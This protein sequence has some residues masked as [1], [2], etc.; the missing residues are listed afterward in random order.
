MKKTISLLLVLSIMLSLVACG[1]NQ[2]PKTEAKANEETK[3]EAM[4]IG[5]VCIG[6]ENEGYS[7]AHIDALRKAVNELGLDEKESLIMKYN[8]AE[9]ASA[10]DACVDLAEQGC[11][12]IITNSYSHQKYTQ[13][14]AGEYPDVEFCAMTGDTAKVSG[15]ANFHNAFT[16]IYQGRYIGGAVAGL[17]L[18]E[19]IDEGKITDANKDVDGKIK[20]GYVGAYPFAEVVSGYTAFFLGIRSIVPDV[21]M[22]V[23]YTNSWGNMIAEKEAATALIN[24][25]CVII[26]QHA[27]TTGA[28]SATEE[29]L[30][31]G[32]VCYTVGYN[33]DMVA[34][35]PNA[36]L[37]SPANNWLN[38]YKY[39]V[40]AVMNGEKFD[41]NWAEGFESDSVILSTPTK[42]CANGTQEKINELIQ[43]FKSKSLHVFDV[44]TFTVGG[45]KVESAF[46]T[47]TNG[48]FTPD[49]DEAV[50]DGYFHESYF[51]SAPAFSLRI[52]GIKE[53]N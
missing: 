49:T 51:Q 39:V 22:Q 30:N 26:G 9:D 6:D 32:H 4:K 41:Q 40:K 13:Q 24:D 31:A 16:K 18:K 44:N 17:K 27:D 23:Q 52:D 34:A 42:N 53:L 33:V 46:A 48:D 11:K 8:I 3:T 43:K 36:A 10:Y 35:A 1:N 2:A 37:I 21:A 47:D 45:N 12:L 29:L 5:L 19:L 28:P 50:F 7:F 38:Y 20:I 25:G 15:L 14:A